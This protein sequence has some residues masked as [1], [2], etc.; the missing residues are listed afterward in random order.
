MGPHPIDRHLPQ[1]QVVDLGVIGEEG[2]I[3]DV[4]FITRPDTTHLSQRDDAHRHE[5]TLA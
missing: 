3:A 5:A 1:E 4:T 2:E